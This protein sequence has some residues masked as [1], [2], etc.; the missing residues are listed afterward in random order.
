M[1]KS[2]TDCQIV[3]L[4]HGSYFDSASRLISLH[5]NWFLFQF[6]L[7][8]TGLLLSLILLLIRL[9]TMAPKSLHRNLPLLHVCTT[10]GMR[11]L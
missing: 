5:A 6:T 11:S 9:F 3:V 4:I 1:D 10:Y 8:F 7:A 2:S